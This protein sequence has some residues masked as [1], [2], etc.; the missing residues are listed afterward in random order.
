[1]SFILIRYIY[2]YIYIYI[3][4][5]ISSFGTAY[6]FTCS[7]FCTCLLCH[8][9]HIPFS[10]GEFLRNFNIKVGQ[11]W[12]CGSSYNDL[13][14]GETGAFTCDAKAIGST[15]KITIKA[16]SF[17]AFCEVMVFGKGMT[18]SNFN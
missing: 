8:I 1:M 3:I 5:S 14:S 12:T 4:Y 10:L 16:K 15:L 17:L 18:C 9:H 13:D 7:C 6:S 2:I 11:Y